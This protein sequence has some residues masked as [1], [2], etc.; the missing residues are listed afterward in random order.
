MEQDGERL[1]LWFGHMTVKIMGKGLEPPVEGLRRQVVYYIQAFHVS[2]VE[3]RQ[4][5]RWVESIKI[6]K[7][8][9]PEELGRWAG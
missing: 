8:A 9:E 5:P 7:A 1:T 3:A 4:E 2:G 6:E